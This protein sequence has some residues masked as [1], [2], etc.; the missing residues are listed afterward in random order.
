MEIERDIFT[1][2]LEWKNSD[3]RRPLLIQGARQIGKTW[4][5][6]K[7]GQKYYS[8]YVYFNFDSNEELK[9]EFT[10]T[11]EPERLLEILR[12]YSSAPIIPKET[13]IIFDEIQECPE[14]LNSLKYFYEEAPDYHI[15]AAGS[16]LGVAI[17]R[18]KGFPV[19]KV[20]FIRMYP[21]SFR[22]YLRAVKTEVYDYINNLSEICGLPAIIES[23][24][25]E[26]YR[27]YQVCG[28]MP[29]A[30]VS[31]IEHSGLERVIAEQREILTSYY[32][33]F[34]KH[35]PQTIFPKIAAVWQSLPSQLSKE[36]RK[37]VYKVVK[38]G[39]RAREYEDALTWLKEAGLIYQVY[40]LSKPGLPLSAFDDLGAFKI[41]LLDVGLLRELAN[42]PPS[43]FTSESASFVEFKGAL[44][45][46]TVLENLL[47]AI[48]Q[49]PR[50]WVSNGT[51]EVDY[52]IQND[53]E[54]IPIEVKSSVNT[55]SKSL[56]VYIGKYKP[57][58]AII[59]SAQGFSI[60]SKDESTQVIHLPIPMAGWLPEILKIASSD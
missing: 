57:S 1:K 53:L 25:W 55:S 46:N 19:G 12:L 33:D 17:H 38:N 7:F 54:I 29:R 56:S 23:K 26:A 18:H 27:Q 59:L 13:L 14:A 22:E 35:A 44:T 39:A 36:N 51:A 16:L 37:F 15:M 34:S 47:P 24:M 11:K 58:T 30:V 40:C 31:S 4:V 3:Y 8:S 6:K 42:I 2:L 10:R 5:M 49:M 43:I 21:I 41:Y 32:F 20:D 28:G 9:S 60:S 45:E 48:E 50:Y 52:I